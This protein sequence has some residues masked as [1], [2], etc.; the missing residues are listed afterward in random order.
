MAK[1]QQ[2]FSLGLYTGNDIEPKRTFKITSNQFT[3]KIVFGNKTTAKGDFK[4]IV[5]NHEKQ[6]NYFVNGK[7]Y[8]ALDFTLSPNQYKEFDV[9]FNVINDGFHSLNYIIVREPSLAPDKLEKSLELLQLYNIRIN[10]LKNI[11]TIPEQRPTVTTIGKTNN[12]NKIHGVFVSK[13]GTNYTAW[14]TENVS[15]NS[16]DTGILNYNLIYG[17][18]EQSP[19]DFYLVTMLDWKQVPFVNDKLLVYDKLNANEEKIISA[20]LD[21]NLLNKENNI[22]VTFMLPEPFTELPDENPYALFSPISSI[23]TNIIQN[24]K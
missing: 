14:L 9:T 24:Q 5:F 7:E 18:K 13:P 22:F 12:E 21:S 1:G 23:R 4:L 8:L 17:N 11:T 19:V 10:L 6:I 16:S 2:G 20:Q 3:K 15:L